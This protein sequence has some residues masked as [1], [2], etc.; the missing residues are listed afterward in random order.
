MERLQ[1]IVIEAVEQSGRNDIPEIIFLDDISLQD[2]EN[3]ENIIFHTDP[4]NSQT[5][6]DISVQN[7]KNI[8]L[9]VGPE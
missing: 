3:Q 7:D 2:F 8:N 4:K 6:K 9:F 1:K 5:L